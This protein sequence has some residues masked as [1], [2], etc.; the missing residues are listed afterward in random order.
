MES[1]ELPSIAYTTDHMQ[2]ENWILGLVSQVSDLA[3]NCQI[4]TSLGIQNGT[5]TFSA[6][7]G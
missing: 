2:Y 5:H 6:A 1:R 4:E 3:H 7:F